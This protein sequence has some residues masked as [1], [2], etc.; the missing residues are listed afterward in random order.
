MG[1]AAQP[2]RPSSR[3]CA[4]G[5]GAWIRAGADRVGVVGELDGATLERFELRGRVVVAEL[6]LDAVTAAERGPHRSTTPCRASPPVTQDLSVTVPVARR[7]GEAL[8]VIR[9]AGGARSS[10]V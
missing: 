10:S 7:A 6:R 3:G 2:S 9:E 5:R 1:R 8:A 4:P